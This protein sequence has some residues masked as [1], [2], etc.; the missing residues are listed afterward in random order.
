MKEL[1]EIQQ[2]ILIHI[3]K[4]GPDNPWYTAR[5]LLGE[6]GWAPKYNEDEI[7]SACKELEKMGYLIRYQGALKRTLTSSIRPWLKVKA[8]EIN[9][10]PKGIYFDL[11]REGRKIASKLYKQFKEDKKNPDKKGR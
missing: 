11:S 7:E 4:Y 8:K 9:H 2:K 3:Y 10:K 1:N 5:R 6:S